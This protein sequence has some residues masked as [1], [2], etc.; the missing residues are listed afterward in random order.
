MREFNEKYGLS[1]LIKYL[2][3][4]VNHKQLKMAKDPQKI[5]YNHYQKSD[6]NHILT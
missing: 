5:T 6:S 3:R 4:S 2:K 1:S